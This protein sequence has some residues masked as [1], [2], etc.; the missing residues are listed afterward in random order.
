MEAE[1][2]TGKQLNLEGARAAALAGDQAAL[3]AELR[4]EVGTIAEFEGMNVMQRQAMAKAFG[5][6]VDQMAEMLN[7]QAEMEAMQKKTGGAYATQSDAQAAFNKLVEEGMSTEQA[8]A[9]MKEQGIDSALTA[10]LASANQSDKI[11]AL[12]EKLGDIFISMMGPI[13]DALDPFLNILM[14]IMSVV[15]GP[16][17]TAFKT[18]GNIITPIFDVIMGIKDIIV[19]LFDPTKSLQETFAEMGPVTA[20]MAVAFGIIG[21]AILGSMVPGLITSAASAIGLAISM[22]ATAVASIASASALTLGI[23]IVAIVAGIAVAVMA[24]KSATKDVGDMMIPS[25]GQTTV[26]TKEGGIFNLSPNDDLVAAPG[27]IDMM[28]NTSATSDVGNMASPTSTQTS[29]SSPGGNNSSSSEGNVIGID[30]NKLL[31]QLIEAVNAG[32]DVY[33]D[34]NKVGKSLAIATSNMG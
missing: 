33:L 15:A 16:L 28:N 19:S 25:E 7:K 17:G 13:A 9:K 3:A 29:S 34:G 24:M 1:L 2:M 20:G 22:A 8:A 18:L 5:M 14:E 4:K 6:N 21:A 12:T 26:S 32:G 30:T 31:K 11:N 23:G 27:A 10:Q